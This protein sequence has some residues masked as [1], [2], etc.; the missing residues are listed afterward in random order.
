M[1][2]NTVALLG[3]GLGNDAAI[4]IA[5]HRP[6]VIFALDKDATETALGLLRR[7]RLLFNSSRVV[8]LPK[9]LKNMQEQELSQFLL[10]V[11]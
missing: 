5:A 2:V 3:A 7:H 11:L 6:D 9:D 1:Y 4:E 8:A 10:E